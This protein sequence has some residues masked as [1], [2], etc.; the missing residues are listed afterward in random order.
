MDGCPLEKCFNKVPTCTPPP[1]GRPKAPTAPSPT[2]KVNRNISEATEAA[3]ILFQVAHQVHPDI[4]AFPPHILAYGTVWPALPSC[5][6]AAHA[7]YVLTDTAAPD[8][9]TQADI[10]DSKRN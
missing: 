9:V 1:G 8:T 3:L 10:K 2:T 4:P 7:A 6:S 5:A